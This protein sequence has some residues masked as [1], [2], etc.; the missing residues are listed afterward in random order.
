M[1]VVWALLG[2]AAVLGLLAAYAF[3]RAFLQTEA[4]LDRTF[5]RI[6]F[7]IDELKSRVEDLRTTVNSKT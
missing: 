2:V 6:E 4:K 5:L 1:I 3:Y 7:Q